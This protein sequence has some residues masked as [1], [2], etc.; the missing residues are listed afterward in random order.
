M[1]ICEGEG[2]AIVPENHKKRNY[3][4]NESSAFARM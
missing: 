3:K 4:K 2:R 1:E